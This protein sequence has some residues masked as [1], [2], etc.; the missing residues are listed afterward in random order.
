MLSNQLSGGLA[1]TVV[2]TFPHGYLLCQNQEA[3]RSP[4]FANDVSIPI[5]DVSQ[6]SS[7]K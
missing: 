7:S 5:P 2:T 4:D 6:V 3:S 1:I